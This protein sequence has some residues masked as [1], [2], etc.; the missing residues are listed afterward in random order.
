MKALEPG[1]GAHLNS[2]KLFCTSFSK[3]SQRMG[4]ANIFVAYTACDSH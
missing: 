3:G 4:L 2:A 1:T